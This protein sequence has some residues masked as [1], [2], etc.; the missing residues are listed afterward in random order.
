MTRLQQLALA[1]IALTT[2]DAGASAGL[3]SAGVGPQTPTNQQEEPTLAQVAPT[4]ANN[5]TAPISIAGNPVAGTAVPVGG[6]AANGQ[7]PNGAATAAAA[8]PAP[9]VVTP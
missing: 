2:F 7:G 8:A 9:R 3:T 4:A 6:A 1:L 5:A